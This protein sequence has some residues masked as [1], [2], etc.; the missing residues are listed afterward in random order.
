MAHSASNIP[1]TA[2]GRSD[3]SH[4]LLRADR[5]GT[6]GG[7][8]MNGSNWRWKTLWVGVAG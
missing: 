6:I 4:T 8:A 1:A 7:R 5:L 3:D 2:C